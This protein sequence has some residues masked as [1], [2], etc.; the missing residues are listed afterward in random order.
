MQQVRKA[1]KP[2]LPLLRWLM[3]LPHTLTRISGAS[4]EEY[5][6]LAKTAAFA[7]PT[8]G[9]NRIYIRGLV[10]I[11][12][13]ALLTRQTIAI[14]PKVSRVIARWLASLLLFRRWLGAN[15]PAKKRVGLISLTFFFA[16]DDLMGIFDD[17]YQQSII[18]AARQPTAG[19][20]MSQT[21][22]L[23]DVLERD[24]EP[25]D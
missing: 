15:L 20:S 7:R 4:S 8:G 13:A 19:S 11:F 21:A 22:L 1:A 18:D 16:R 9:Q 12:D 3:R 24:F 23:K 14:F 2:R 6:A 17:G 5:Q 10:V 25:V